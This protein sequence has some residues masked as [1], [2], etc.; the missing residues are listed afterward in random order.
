[1]NT[2][3]M[4]SS[5]VSLKNDTT[6]MDWTLRERLGTG[7]VFRRQSALSVEMSIAQGQG[8]TEHGDHNGESTSTNDTRATLFNDTVV[9]NHETIMLPHPNPL[10][11]SYSRKKYFHYPMAML[12]LSSPFPS[13]VWVF[14]CGTI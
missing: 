3:Q 12:Y 8:R 11:L 14:L 10:T 13:G 7:V 1:M 4:D 2:S 5:V 9:D 6:G